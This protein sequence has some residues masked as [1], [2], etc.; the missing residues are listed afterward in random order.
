MSI[1]ESDNQTENMPRFN[2]QFLDHQ[3]FDNV[4]CPIHQGW[5]EFRP[6]LCWDQIEERIIQFTS[7]C[8]IE[9]APR[10]LVPSD[11]MAWLETHIRP[12]EQLNSEGNESE[13]RVAAS[14]AW[15]AYRELLDKYDVW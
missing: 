10:T 11:I 3:Y 1:Q 2:V 8:G 9:I 4:L 12:L 6:N 7:G 5:G 13:F 14:A 15:I